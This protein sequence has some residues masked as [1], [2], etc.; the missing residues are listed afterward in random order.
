MTN[1]LLNN[2]L[3]SIEN[4]LATEENRLFFPNKN[5]LQTL[6]NIIKETLFP[7]FYSQQPLEQ[8]AVRDYLKNHFETLESLLN[9]EILNCFLINESDKNDNITNLYKEK[10]TSITKQFLGH[11]VSL[12][13]TLHKD[14]SAILESDPAAKSLL[15]VML[16][17]P[18][19]YAIMVYRV[20]HFFHRHEIPLIP[21]IFTEMA[22]VETGI[23]IHPGAQIGDSFSI[24]HGTG[25]VIGETTVIGKHV[26]LYQGVTLGAFSVKE[27]QEKTKRHPTIEDHVTI[28]SMSTILGG[29][30]TIGQHSIIGGNVWL[31]RSLKPR[32]KIYLSQDFNSTYTLTND[33]EPA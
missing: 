7:G 2:Y 10:A 23:D 3:N 18:G 14:A 21:R 1:Q 13:Q 30:T 19:F 9:Q 11:L 6:L 31:T 5:R 12:R 25:I 24:D 20:A 16:A 4:S 26:K 17:Y 29:D 22:H 27:G 33:K 28:Y 8:N 32:S 15:E